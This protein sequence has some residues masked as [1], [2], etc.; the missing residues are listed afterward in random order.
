VDFFESKKNLARFYQGYPKISSQIP[1]LASVFLSVLKTFHHASVF[2]EEYLRELDKHQI[3]LI[4]QPK[5][6]E[7]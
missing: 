5:I 1:S 3:P 4:P 7:K 2:F 6:Q